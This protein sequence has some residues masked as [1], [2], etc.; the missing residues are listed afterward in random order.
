M[1]FY[2]DIISTAGRTLL[3]KVNRVAAGV[4]AAIWAPRWPTRHANNSQDRLK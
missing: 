4:D 1:P 2:Q 3:T